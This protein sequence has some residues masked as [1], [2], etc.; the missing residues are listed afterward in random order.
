MGWDEMR[1]DEIMVGQRATHLRA[2]LLHLRHAQIKSHQVTSSLKA[3]ARTLAPP[4]PRSQA[5]RRKRGLHPPAKRVEPRRSAAPVSA[6]GKPSVRMLLWQGSALLWQRPQFECCCGKG[7]AAAQ[8]CCCC[9]KG[10]YRKGPLSAVARSCVRA[11]SAP[12]SRLCMYMAS[13]AKSSQVGAC[14]EVRIATR[15]GLVKGAARR[16]ARAAHARARTLDQ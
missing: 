16:A 6:A 3:P 9:G 10:C 8:L 14:L 11:G 15:D 5:P 12:A 4:P 1:W 7:S 2:D 13:H